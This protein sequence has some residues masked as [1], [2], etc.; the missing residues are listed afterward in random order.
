MG[1]HKRNLRTNKRK[2]VI[3]KD[4]I[5][6]RVQHMTVKMNN[7]ILF[8][9]GCKPYSSTYENINLCIP[10]NE[11]YMFNM[12]SEQWSKHVL[13]ETANVPPY[14]VAACAVTIGRDVFMAGGAIYDLEENE[15]LD[16][17]DALWKLSK[18]SGHFTWHRIT[19]HSK[20]AIPAPMYRHQGWEYDNKMYTFGGMNM[21]QQCSFNIY[22]ELMKVEGGSPTIQSYLTNQLNCFDPIH[23]E[24]TNVQSIGTIPSPRCDVG[25]T[26]VKESVYV[27]GGTLPYR[28]VADDLYE[29]NMPTLTWVKLAIDES[30]APLKRAGHSLT[31]T[32]NYEIILHGGCFVHNRDYNDTWALF[33][34]TLTWREI[35]R[36]NDEPRCA[37]SAIKL[38]N[39]ILIIGGYAEYHENP[40]AI[41]QLC[42]TRQPMSLEQLS[43]RSVHKYRNIIQPEDCDMPSHCYER[44]NDMI[45]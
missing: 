38:N 29:L 41:S 33:L 28:D 8:F 5:H 42:L 3:S 16:Y 22:G 7:C 37:H 17:T 43:L 23:Q 44:F 6:T 32:G 4:D 10:L 39:S 1:K 14:T 26:Q 9:G 40:Q 11:I 27:H 35:T 36:E 25:C 45:L 13:P 2:C 30:V 15:M 21:T 18:I 34:K 20:K 24:W 19:F 12:D 31:A